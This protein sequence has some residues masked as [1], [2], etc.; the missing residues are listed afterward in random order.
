M[1]NALQN[2]AHSIERSLRP[3]MR[4]FA[5]GVAVAASA[6]AFAGSFDVNP[7]R[8]EL[9]AQSRTTVVKVKNTGE[10]SVVV[11][12]SVQGLPAGLTASWTQN[13]AGVYT[14]RLDCAATAQKFLFANLTITGKL[15]TVTKTAPLSVTLM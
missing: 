2:L 3:V 7:I 8:V 5:A 11:Q 12:M 14:L 9:T 4:L 13:A 6:P 10:D 1:G 15:G